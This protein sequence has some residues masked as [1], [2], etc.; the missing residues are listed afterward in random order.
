MLVWDAAAGLAASDRAVLDLHLAE[1]HYVIAGDPPVVVQNPD[2][3]EGHFFPGRKKD[4]AWKGPG[5]L[6]T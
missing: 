3:I 1:S 6:E 4:L 5:Y 2:R